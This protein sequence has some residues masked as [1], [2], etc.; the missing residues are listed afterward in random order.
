MVNTEITQFQFNK[1]QIGQ[2]CNLLKE[3]KRKVRDH[4]DIP[5][6]N[7]LSQVIIYLNFASNF[8]NLMVEFNLVDKLDFHEVENWKFPVNSTRL[9]PT[10]PELIE[11]TPYT[12]S[13][14]IEWLLHKI[15]SVNITLKHLFHINNDVLKISY[16]QNVSYAVFTLSTLD[17][18]F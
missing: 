10:D 17:L 11:M 3:L 13:Q 8:I 4:D 6:N 1:F 7:T 12:E 9:S 5:F 15:D 18:G 2:I 14:K 16:F